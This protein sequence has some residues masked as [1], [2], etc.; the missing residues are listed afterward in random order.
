DEEHPESADSTLTTTTNRDIFRLSRNS[1]KRGIRV[2]WNCTAWANEKPRRASRD[3]T[4]DN[5]RTIFVPVDLRFSPV[6]PHETRMRNAALATTRAAVYDSPHRFSH[7]LPPG[8]ISS[9][10]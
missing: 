9:N 5:A 10:K 8:S 4:R 3:L 2:G 6:H 7:D 1:G